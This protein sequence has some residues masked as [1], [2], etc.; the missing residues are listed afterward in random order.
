LCCPQLLEH[1]VQIHKWSYPSTHGCYKR[2]WAF[3]TSPDTPTSG[4]E[5]FVA[6][7]E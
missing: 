5:P 2:A 4:P 1:K 7:K 6:L 3:H